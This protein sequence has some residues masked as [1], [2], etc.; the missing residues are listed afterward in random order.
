MIIASEKYGCTDEV[1]SIA[2]MLDVQNS[3]FYKPKDKAVLADTARNSFSVGGIGDHSVLLSVYNGW[4]DTDFSTQWCFE[5]FVQVRASSPASVRV[6]FSP[7]CCYPVTRQSKAM[8]RAR[9]IREQLEGL[10]ER[11][12]IDAASSSR[13]TDA[14]GKAITAGFFYHAAKL[15]KNGGYRTV[16]NAH[17]VH[18]HPSSCLAKEVGASCAFSYTYPPARSTKCSFRR[19]LPRDGSCFTNS[20]RRPRSSCGRS[21]Q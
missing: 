2:A 13:D 16:K 11:V 1:L 12:E 15:Q 7:P 5:N 17:T 21:L 20:W 18:I 6:H 4:R 8:K 3:V 9:D 10:C 19:K 14:L